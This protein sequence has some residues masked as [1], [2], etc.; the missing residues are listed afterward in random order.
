MKTALLV[1]MMVYITGCQNPGS[2]DLFNYGEEFELTFGEASY[3]GTDTTTV[4]FVDVL[5]DSRCPRNVTCI[6]AG[7]GKV[8]L[9]FSQKMVRLNTYLD[10]KDSTVS[11]VN[12]QLLSLDPYPEYPDNIKK[13]DY[14]I[15]L[16]LSKI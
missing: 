1:L 13:E 5:E 11:E 8:Q 4:E 2:S 16:L 6:W 12:I 14:R 3:V 10:P 15:H 9:R 7:N